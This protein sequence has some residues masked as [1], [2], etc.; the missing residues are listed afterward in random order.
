LPGDQHLDSEC[1]GN[2]E[3]VVKAADAEMVKINRLRRELTDTAASLTTERQRLLESLVQFED[4][5]KAREQELSEIA[6][7]AVSTERASYNQLV[8]ERAE[9]RFKLD[10]IDRLKRL[11]AQRPELDAERP[12]S[13]GG[14]SAT[15]TQVS[16]NVLDE[17]AQTI[18]GYYKSGISR[19]LRAYSLTRASA[20]SR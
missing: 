18:E 7:P 14:P 9:V 1:D 3:A 17:F 16:K 12:E 13:A 8:S 20:I 10:K 11:T 6:S 4:E 15:K 5:Y 2:T 19:M